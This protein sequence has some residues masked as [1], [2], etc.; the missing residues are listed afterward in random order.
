MRSFFAVLL[1]LLVS[2]V[3]ISTANPL[4]YRAP[5]MVY[6]GGG[7]PQKFLTMVLYRILYST[8]SC[9]PRIFLS[10]AA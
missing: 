7:F 10:E 2:A 9:V 8:C 3:V 5:Q 4:I 6:F 1:T